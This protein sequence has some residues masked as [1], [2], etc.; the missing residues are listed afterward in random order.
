MFTYFLVHIYYIIV[1]VLDRITPNNNSKFYFYFYDYT[2][3][4]FHYIQVPKLIYYHMFKEF[5]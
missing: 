2:C 1:L 4:Y 5:P 3:N